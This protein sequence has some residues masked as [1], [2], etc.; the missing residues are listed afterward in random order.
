M[1]DLYLDGKFSRNAFINGKEYLFFSGYDYLSIHENKDFLQLLN[2]GLRKY[3]WLYASARISNTKIDLFEKCE[4]YLSELTESEATVLYGSGFSSGQAITQLFESNLENSPFSHP[5]ILKKKNTE[6]D[7]RKWQQTCAETIQSGTYPTFAS[8]TVNNFYVE[9][10]DFNFLQTLDQSANFI[11]DDSHGFGITGVDGKGVSSYIQKA[12]NINY[13]YTYSLGKAF[14]IGAGAVSTTREIAN[15]LHK[16]PSFAAVTP[17]PPAQLYAFLHANEIYLTQL[18]KL[19]ANIQL[20]AQL[21]EGIEDIKL[22]PELPLALLPSSL[23]ETDFLKE[24]CIIS[25][26]A[27]PD[28]KGPKLNRLVINAAH[29]ENDLE[30]I[31]KL[32]K[33]YLS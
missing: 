15:Q 6:K 1:S 30:K 32:V 21:F 9:K 28:P 2:E 20:M 10:Y 27:Y 16:Q 26:F 5:A 3:G 12:K 7:V 31:T 17:P 29:T 19:K 4:A 33:K 22:H 25:S 8:D 14:G 23:N 18:E 24:N 11:L 13:S